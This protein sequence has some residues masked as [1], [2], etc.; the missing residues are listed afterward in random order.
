[1]EWCFFL[2]LCDARSVDATSF[3]P[4]FLRKLC[5]SAV[6]SAVTIF[7]EPDVALTQDGAADVEIVDYH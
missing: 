2:R 6:N 5:A 4:R 7:D 1:M 3:E